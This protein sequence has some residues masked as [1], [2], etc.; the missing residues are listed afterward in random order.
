MQIVMNNSR[1]G[2]RPAPGQDGA[3]VML[4]QDQ[5]GNEVVVPLSRQAQHELRTMLDAT[6]TGLV[7]PQPQV[8][9]L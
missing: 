5:Q 8:V 2:F 3:I 1:I 9:K 6:G 7:I 4:V